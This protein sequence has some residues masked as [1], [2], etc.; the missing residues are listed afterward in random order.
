MNS[1]CTI[2]FLILTLAVFDSGN[3]LLACPAPQTKDSRSLSDVNAI[4]HRNLGKSVNL[5][6]LDKE[7][8][9]GKQ[10]ALEVERSSK[11]LNDP[12]VTEYVYR[13]AQKIA[14]NSD[15]RLPIT[16]R[17]ID[18]DVVD[19]FTL[20]GGYQ[21]INSGLLFKTEGEAE[22]AGVLARG[23]AHTALRSSTIEATKGELMQLASPPAMIFIPN[24]MAA[25]HAMY[26]GLNLTI[27]VT[28]LKFR[29]D[30]ERAADFFGLQY[31]YKAGYDPEC[32]IRF[33][34][35]VWPQP[36]NNIS[37]VFNPFPPLPERLQNMN[38]EI[39]TILPRQNA[40]IVSSSEFQL[41]K[42]RLREWNSQ[43]VPS[44]KENDQKPTLRRRPENRAVEPPILMPDCD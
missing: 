29:R 14:R 10:L 16:I 25:G 27:P 32:Y 7:Q 1:H 34:E 19:A 5:C 6:S 37:E 21:Y 23:I 9:L 36:T 4:G 31:L 11:F 17:I 35:R 42:E 24:S 28:F 13:L 44:P 38:K 20:P 8:E 12:A 33:L 2:P 43:R 15:A 40:A 22:L 26:Q 3:L 18:S 39:T 30:E 41:V